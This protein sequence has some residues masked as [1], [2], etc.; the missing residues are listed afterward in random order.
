[1]EMCNLHLEKMALPWELKYQFLCTDATDEHKAKTVT[2]LRKS[3]Q[4]FVSLL[5]EIGSVQELHK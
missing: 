2:Q 3:V 5:K 4:V 1:M